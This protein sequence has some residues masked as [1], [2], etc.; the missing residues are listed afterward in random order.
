[1]RELARRLRDQAALLGWLVAV[2]GLVVAVPV[3]AL[4]PAASLLRPVVWALVG[5]T[6]VIALVSALAARPWTTL[7]AGLVAC[8]APLVA[9][10]ALDKPGVDR[11][12]SGLWVALAVLG[13]VDAALAREPG[14]VSLRR[15]VRWPVARGERFLA[16]LGVLWLAIAWFGPSAALT[17]PAHAKALRVAGA[18]VCWSV[19][20][21]TVATQRAPAT[22]KLALPALAGRRMAWLA[23]VGGLLWAWQSR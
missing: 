8:V 22:G 20:A 7:C 14:A 12:W 10:P 18:A 6:P 9:C 11:P 23:L 17:A 4:W 13:A 16:A 21:G 1:M 2:W 3:A 19:V 15:W 5:A